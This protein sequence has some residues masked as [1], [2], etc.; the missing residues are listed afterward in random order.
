[1]NTAKGNEERVKKLVLAIGK[2]SLPR[3]Q[4]VAEMGL[5]QGSRHIFRNN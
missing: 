3:R 5:M 1:M 2:T 4:L